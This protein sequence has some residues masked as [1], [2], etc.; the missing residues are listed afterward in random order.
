MSVSHASIPMV[1]RERA[2]LQPAEPAFTFIDYTENPAG[3]AESLNWSQVDGRA[4]NVAREIRRTGAPGDRA[5]ILAPQGLHYIAAFLGALEA[6]RVAVPLTVP[7]GPGD[8]HVHSVLRDARPSVVLTTSSVVDVVSQYI[9]SD[10][11]A[12][13]PSIVEI[14]ALDLDSPTGLDLPPE[15]NVAYLQYTSGSTRRPTGVMVSQENLLTNYAQVM[16]AYFSRYEAVPPPDTTVVSWVPLSHN[17]GLFIG[18]CAPVLAGLHTVFTSPMS[19]IQQPSRWMRLLANNS[20]AFSPAPNFALELAVQMTSD[21][22]MTGHDLRDVMAIILGGERIQAATLQRF[23]Q[24]FARLGLRESVMRPSYGLAEATVYVATRASGHVPQIVHFKPDKQSSGLAERCT[25]GTG[26]AL[27]SYGAPRSPDVKIVDPETK[28]ECAPGTIG[29]IWV[30]G[31]NVA[32]GYWEKPEESSETFGARLVGASNGTPAEPW[33]RTG[34]LGAISDGELFIMGRIKD[35]LIVYGRNHYPDDI[36]STIQEI[37]G[38][39]AAAIAVPD[40]STEKL[41]AIVEVENGDAFETVKNDVTAALSTAH[42]L[43]IADL[44]PVLPGSIPTT[45][46]GKVKRTACVEHYVKRSFNRLDG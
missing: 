9:P 31:D 1:L 44:V 16:A 42:G 30:H 46:S 18:L 13:G 5:V 10:R 27:L 32:N 15:P 34:D 3:D 41:V 36:E 11:D 40:D 26:T 38:G 8:D 25:D 14:D 22:D 24:R 45:T 12:S 17:M 39:R 20:R 19:F 2:D 23:T 6:G 35:L 7:F 29:E 33:L 28:A 21:D 43:S 37:T 4:R